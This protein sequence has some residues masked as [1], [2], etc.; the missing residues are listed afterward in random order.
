MFSYNDMYDY[1]RI[2]FYNKIGSYTVNLGE[3]S[4]ID[5]D[6]L[7]NLLTLIENMHFCIYH[8]KED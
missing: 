2:E 5:K 6:D 4:L 3:S 8:K 7:D 1:Y